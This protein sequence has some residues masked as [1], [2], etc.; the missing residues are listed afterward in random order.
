[1]VQTCYMCEVVAT[2]E[3]HAPPRCIFPE[4]KDVPDQRDLR[5]NLITVPSCEQHNTQKSRDD[6]YLLFILAA[7]ITSS[8]VGLN[9]FLTK[10]RR[11]AERKPAL[12]IQIG[13]TAQPVFLHDIQKREW[14]E[15]FALEVD[16][17]RIDE[18]LIKCAR[19]IYYHEKGS[20]F[21]GVVRLITAFTLNPSNVTLN[22]NVAKAF[23]YADQYFGI[24]EKNGENPEVF[25]YKIAENNG[26]AVLQM[27][28]YEATKVLAYFC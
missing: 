4:K 3:E 27:I 24:E 2:T 21:A 5:K 25:Y 26:T 16:G 23:E 17:R 19:A 20:M 1:M 15:G 10:V 11:A 28:F 8:D 14:V 18:A 22:E 7:S 12:A 13:S 9:Q 6:E